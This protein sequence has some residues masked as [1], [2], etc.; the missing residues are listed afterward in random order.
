MALTQL[1]RGG[2]HLCLLDLSHNPEEIDMPDATIK[3]IADFFRTGDAERDRLSN[4]ANEW[5]QLNDDDKAEIRTLV[6]AEI[7]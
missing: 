4:F 5:K 3:Q 6:T 1:A 7:A 2:C